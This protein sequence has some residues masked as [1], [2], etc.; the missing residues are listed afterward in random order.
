MSIINTRLNKSIKSAYR[1]GVLILLLLALG[2]QSCAAFAQRKKKRK[3]LE[4]TMTVVAI[5]PA[6]K[7]ETFCT[8]IF[9]QSARFYKLP[10]NANPAYLELL[11]KSEQ[12]KTPITILR[13]NDE[14]DM[15]LG[16][17]K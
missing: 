15:I 12:T 7:D 2:L 9:S 4:T 1:T 17:K 11:K 8:V 3:Q 6:A 14:S 10:N 13:T 16:V 5:R